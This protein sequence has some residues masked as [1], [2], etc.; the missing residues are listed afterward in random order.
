MLLGWAAMRAPAQVDAITTAA[1]TSITSLTM[2]C[3]AT[4]VAWEGPANSPPGKS[5]SGDIAPIIRA[6]ISH[7]PTRKNL[8]VTKHRPMA[9]SSAAIIT[10]P[11]P[12][13]T[14][15]KVSAPVVL[16]ARP[17][18]GPRPREEPESPEGHEDE[19]QAHAQQRYAV[20]DQPA[21]KGGVHPV[22]PLG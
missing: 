8:P 4:V 15:P 19:P 13:G 6:P 14:S 12:G 21:A 1:A 17:S 22:E 3:A 9:H 18:M 7:T 5:T 2:C 16:V 11:T 10:S 20:G